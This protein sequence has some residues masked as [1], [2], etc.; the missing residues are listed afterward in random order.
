MLKHDVNI[1]FNECFGWLNSPEV[2]HEIVGGKSENW[3]KD[4]SKDGVVKLIGSCTKIDVKIIRRMGIF[5]SL[6]CL[7][8][9]KKMSTFSNS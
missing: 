4:T 1:E 7:L 3:H 8:E 2:K 5:V 9:K 6:L